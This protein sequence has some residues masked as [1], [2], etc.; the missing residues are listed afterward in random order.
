[1]PP[2]PKA[3]EMSDKLID[4]QAD[5]KDLLHQILSKLDEQRKDIKSLKEDMS[6]VKEDVA[7]LKGDMTSLK[8]QVELIN[9]NQQ[10]AAQRSQRDHAEIMEYL[11]TVADVAGGEHKALEKRVDRIEKH[12]NLLPV[13]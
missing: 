2:A 12:L 6:S 13:K 1:M 4:A 5:K 11:V 8:L 9:A 3:L 10:R 7:S